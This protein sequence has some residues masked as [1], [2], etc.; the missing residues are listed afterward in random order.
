MR[1]AN[2]IELF[3]AQGLNLFNMAADPCGADEDRHRRP[4]CQ[5]TGLNPAQYGTA[6]LDNPAGQYNYLQGGNPALNPEKSKSYTV[7]LVLQ[8]IANLS[9]TV[10][11]WNIKVDNVIGVIGANLALQQCL[12]AGQFCNLIH[13]DPTLGTLWLSGGFIT[14]TN[15][16][17]GTYKTDGV[18]VTVN[19]NYPME[20]YGS[21]AFAFTGTYLNEFI[22]QPVPGLGSYNCAGLYGNT[23]GPPLPKWRSNLRVMWTTPWSWNA[24]LTWRYF[25]SVDIDA[26]SSNPQLT[27]PS[28]S[29]TPRSGRGTTSTSWRSGTST[30]TSRCGAASTTSSTRIRRITSIG[31]L[32]YY[33]GNTYPQIYDALGRNFF[34]NVTAKF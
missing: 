25:D 10:D 18:D 24:G 19:Y 20:K 22:I 30:R 7:G 1:A 9:G 27:G 17:L 16:N 29:P 33:N 13:R 28:T 12:N 15:L 8:P 4:Q 21:L 23:C 2:I 34:L 32:P 31:D 3:A 26:S 11:Y 6:I 5:Q 14:N